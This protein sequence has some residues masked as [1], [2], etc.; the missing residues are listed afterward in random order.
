MPDMNRRRGYSLIEIL[1]VITVGSVMLGVAVAM[2]HTLMQVQEDSREWLRYHTTL[3]RLGRQFRCDVHA[4]VGFQPPEA[5]PGGD[6]PTP[7][8]LD[9]KPDR[10]VRYRVDQ[11]GLIRT[12][13]TGGN[14]LRREAFWLPDDRAVSIR[15]QAETRPPI[16]SLSITSGAG[17]PGGRRWKPVRIDAVL[18]RDHRFTKPSKP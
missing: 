6:P 15:L 1:V 17:G 4:A 18:G 10:V 5:K 11:R 3:G 12:E 8:Q 9:F 2:L 14:L 16:V 7:W 13:Q